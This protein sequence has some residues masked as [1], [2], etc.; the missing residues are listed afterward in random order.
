M[1][2]GFCVYALAQEL[3]LFDQANFFRHATEKE[4]K[5]LQR[6][7]GF[8]DVVV[9]PEL[10]GLHRGFDRSMTGHD[11][12]LGAGQHLFHSFEEGE[13]R[14][15]GHHH[16]GKNDVRGLLF[17]QGQGGVAAVGLHANKPQGFAHGHAQLA[18]TLLIVNDQE[19]D[20]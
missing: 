19:A 6:G 13:A 18:D 17:E 10:H 7:E 12:N 14:H 8:A 16:V 15:I 2:L 11:R 9:G 1:Q 3:V 5:F 4:A 20:S